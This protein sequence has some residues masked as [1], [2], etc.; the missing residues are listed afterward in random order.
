MLRTGKKFSLT[1]GQYRVLQDREK[2]HTTLVAYIKDDSVRRVTMPT[3]VNRNVGATGFGLM[4]MGASWS[5]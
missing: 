1:V 5:Q 3:L 4:S 2:A